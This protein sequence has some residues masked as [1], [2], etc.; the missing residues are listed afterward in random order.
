MW[1]FAALASRVEVVAFSR[2]LDRDD[3]RAAH[4]A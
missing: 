2:P 4:D 1:K 3:E